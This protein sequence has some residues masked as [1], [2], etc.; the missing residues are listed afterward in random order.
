MLFEG[1]TYYGQ[2]LATKEVSI[3]KLEGLHIILLS[4]TNFKRLLKILVCN[5]CGKCVVT[6]AQVIRELS[7]DYYC[8][9]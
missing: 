3:S 9:Q 8:L 4:P 1:L 7:G 2:P 5:T 6:C